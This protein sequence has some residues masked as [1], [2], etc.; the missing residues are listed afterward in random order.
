MKFFDQH[1][2]AS[3]FLGQEFDRFDTDLENEE[4][5]WFNQFRTYV[6]E[7]IDIEI[8]Q[9]LFGKGAVGLLPVRSIVALGMIQ[10]AFGWNDEKA[11]FEA[12]TDARLR[13]AIGVA[14]PDNVPS[15]EAI[16]QLRSLMAAYLSKTGIDLNS[17]VVN[18]VAMPG[19]PVM[20]VGRGR[21]LIIAKRID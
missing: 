9:V 21:M 19:S 17:L 6:T 8:F 11:L 4:K 7:L 10:N 1:N 14:S 18:M 2:T 13:D 12:R 5:E 16:V 3:Y 15:M 20:K